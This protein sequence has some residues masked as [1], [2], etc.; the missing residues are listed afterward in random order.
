LEEMTC[1]VPVHVL[2]GQEDGPGAVAIVAAT[3]LGGQLRL[4]SKGLGAEPAECDDTQQR[5][6]HHHSPFKRR[7]ASDQKQGSHFTSATGVASHE[8]GLRSETII[9]ND[10]VYSPVIQQLGAV[11]NSQSVGTCAECNDRH[12]DQYPDHLALM[13]RFFLKHGLDLWSE[14]FGSV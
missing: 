13:L 11:T 5:T 4:G 3:Q 2:L 6:N 12:G 1:I 8:C 9:E 7:S 14:R 10:H